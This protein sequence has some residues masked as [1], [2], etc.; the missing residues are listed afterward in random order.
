[1]KL[2]RV[3][4]GGGDER[5]KKREIR[6][7]KLEKKNRFKNHF[8]TS[9]LMSLWPVATIIAHPSYGTSPKSDPSSF[10]SSSSSHSF[11]MIH[12]S[13][14]KRMHISLLIHG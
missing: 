5:E 9:S 2:F 12:Y 1:M 6:K 14:C 11:C 13:K 7:P 3:I 8:V 10:S 4:K